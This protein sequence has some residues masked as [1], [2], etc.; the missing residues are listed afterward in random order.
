MGLTTNDYGRMTNN[1]LLLDNNDSFTYNIVDLLR[2]IQGWH[3]DVVKS[4][5]L[6]V[7]ALFEYKKIILSPGP[8]LPQDFP[9]IATCIQHAIDTGK[10][11]LGICLGHQALCRF[12]GGKL[13]RL[14]HPVHGQQKQ[15]TINSGTTLFR[16]L[17]ASIQVG[18][19]HSWQI[20]A[21]SLP[22]CFDNTGSTINGQLMA[23]QHKAFPF[24]GV[25][26][27]PESFLTL[28]G[29]QIIQNFLDA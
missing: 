17:P 6:T 3:F 26:F 24:H 10:G 7:D 14:A 15:I 28:Q 27:H 4:G 18:L 20:D 25:Q 12:F 1:I 23:V 5:A 11:L 8:G 29:K 9:A 16:G 21:D 2:T 19:Y 13:S 22:D